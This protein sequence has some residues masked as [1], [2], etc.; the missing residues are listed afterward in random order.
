LSRLAREYHALFG[1]LP[2]QTLRT[3]H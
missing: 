2:A 3:R 1:E